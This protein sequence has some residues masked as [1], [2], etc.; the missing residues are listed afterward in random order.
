MLTPAA[1]NRIEPRGPSRYS[2]AGEENPHSAAT[3][4][5]RTR[6]AKRASSPVSTKEACLWGPGHA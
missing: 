4:I 3:D 1:F 2:T 5:S 6:S